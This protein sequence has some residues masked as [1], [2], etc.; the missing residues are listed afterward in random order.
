MTGTSGARSPVLEAKLG[1]CVMRGLGPHWGGAGCEGEG[2]VNR[3]ELGLAS[4]WRD[5]ENKY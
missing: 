1:H 4:M 2:H 3:E 5:S